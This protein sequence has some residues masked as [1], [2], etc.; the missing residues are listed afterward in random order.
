LAV[1]GIRGY[2]RSKGL[3]SG[4]PRHLRAQYTVYA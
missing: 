3:A 1:H 4:A 2:A